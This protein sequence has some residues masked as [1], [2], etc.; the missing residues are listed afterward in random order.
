MRSISMD[1]VNRFVSQRMDQSIRRI[2]TCATELIR[3][4]KMKLDV[5]RSLVARD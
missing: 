4:I 2:E 1:A 3:G 5:T